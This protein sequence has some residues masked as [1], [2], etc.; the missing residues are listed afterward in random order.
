MKKLLIWIILI[1]FNIFNA[2]ADNAYDFTFKMADGSEKK[3]SEYQGKVL[4]FVNTASQCG[5]VGQY[6]ILEEI[7]QKYKNDGLEI[8][9]IPSKD[10]GNQ[11]FDSMN[12]VIEFTAKNYNISFPITSLSKV[13]GND[14]H[15]FYLWANLQA[16][17]FGSPKWNFHKYLIDKNGNFVQW[18]S[19]ATN[20][21]SKKVIEAI[22]QELDK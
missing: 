22:E 11:E 19:S 1:N 15:P 16:G 6:K 21:D 13:S 10:F 12:D 5:F 3:L 7:Y 17:F 20:P 4:L 18:F 2:M 8:I 14:A 9:A